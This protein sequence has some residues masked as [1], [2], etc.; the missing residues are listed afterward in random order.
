MRTRDRARGQRRRR[1]GRPPR[2]SRARAARVASSSSSLMSAGNVSSRLMLF[3]S[4]CASTSPWSMPRTRSYSHAAS[5]SPSHCVSVAHDRTAGRRARAASRAARVAPGSAGRPSES[6]RGRTSRETPP[7]SPARRRAR[8]SRRCQASASR[9]R[10]R[11]SRRASTFRRRSTPRDP[12]RRRR[13]CAH[14]HA[15]SSA[16][17]SSSYSPSVPA[18][19]MYHSSMLAPSTTGAIALED[20]AD[21][22]ALLAARAPRNGHAHRVGTQAQRARDRH[23]RAHAELSRLVRRGADDAAALA[24]A[25]DD[26][27]RLLAGALGVDHSRDGDEERVGV[28]EENPTRASPDVQVLDEAGVFAVARDA[29]RSRHDFADDARDVIADIP[30]RPCRR[31]ARCCRRRS[32]SPRPASRDSSRHRHGNAELFF[33]GREELVERPAHRAVE[34]R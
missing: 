4:P 29:E 11:A 22:P 25:A 8:R 30:R 18:R 16:S 17:G 10:R 9:V 26:E 34:T 2:A 7:S 24:R 15:R 6:R 20:G 3:A 14:A 31:S 23:R 28:G 33:D 5:R 1:E 27:Q 19:S 32:R 13:R 12:S 21:L